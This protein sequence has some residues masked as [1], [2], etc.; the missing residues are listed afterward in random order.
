LRPTSL[1]A[2]A[3]GTAES[4]F[5]CSDSTG[6][7]TYTVDP[8]NGANSQFICSSNITTAIPAGGAITA[9]FSSDSTPNAATF[10]E[11]QGL[12]SPKA[13]NGANSGGSTTNAVSSGNITTNQANDLLFGS[14]AISNGPSTTFTPSSVTPP[15]NSTTSVTGG[16]KQIFSYQRP[17]LSTGTY[18]LAGTT[19]GSGAHVE[20]IVAYKIETTPPT[21]TI[22]FPVN[23]AFYNTAGWSGSITG[24]ASDAGA[25]VAGVGVSIRTA[26]PAPAASPSTCS[27]WRRPRPSPARPRRAPRARRS[28]SAA[29]PR[30]RA[31]MRAIA[32]GVPVGE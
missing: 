24:T 5:S 16:S 1:I 32:S 31:R 30:M 10:D 11:F 6:A 27:T 23:G 15:W 29:R 17:V 9:T 4:T 25:G 18:S 12:L 7:N 2:V 14:M 19:S 3:R 13:T 28:L 26:S 21:S 20:A 22:T 8:Q